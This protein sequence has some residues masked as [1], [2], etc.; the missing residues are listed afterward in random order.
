MSPPKKVSVHDI[1]RLAHVS[2]GTV[3]RALHG[4]KEINCDTRKRILRIARKVGYKPNLAARLLA[5][6]RAP[7][8][9]GV[10]I[11]REIHFFYDQ[12]RDGI[13]EEARR[14]ESLGVS[15][16][17]R[18]VTRLGAGEVERARELLDSD[19]RALILAPGDPRGLAPLIEE[20][21]KRRIHVLCVSSDAPESARST[22]ICVDPELNGRCAA[23]LM[24]KF[25]PANSRVAIV[26]GM[27]QVEDHC[28]KTKGFCEGFA[29][30]CKGG[31][32]VEVI[33]N[34]EDEEE[35]RQKCASLLERFPSIGGLYVSTVNCLPVCAALDAAGLSGKV[36]LIT[37]DLFPRMVPHFKNGT[38]S[39]SMYQRPYV[40][41]QTAVR[42]AVDHIVN[43]VPIPPSYYLNPQIVLRS[44]LSL[45]REISSSES[46]ELVEPANEFL[47]F[48]LSAAA[49]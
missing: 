25:V 17:Y 49:R 36:R 18:P 21:E 47:V 2:I 20:A 37:T 35:A 48:S 10:C 27:L 13:M 30:F 46:G 3:D 16:L 23:E 45:F 22:V 42:V 12:V 40:Q 31:K 28:R 5:V 39:A 44:N 15:I 7:L 9:I 11:P 14:F 4:R 26:T 34:H 24:A 32:V 38:I 6:G 19:I 8:C 1:A 33:E 29:S 43:G 41:G